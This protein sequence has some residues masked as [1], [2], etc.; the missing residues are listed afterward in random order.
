MNNAIQGSQSKEAEFRRR[1]YEAHAARFEANPEQV[2]DAKGYQRGFDASAEE[3]LA[4][5]DALARTGDVAAFHDGMKQWAVKPGTLAFNGFSGQMFVNQLVNRSE[6]HGVLA[7][8]LADALSLPR[9]DTDAAAK[10]RALVDYVETIRIGAHPAPGHSNFLLSYFWGLE[11]HARW[12]VLWSSAAAYLEFSTGEPLPPTPPERYVQYLALVRELDTDHDRFERVAS[13]WEQTKPVLLD[14]AL[15]ER[16]AFGL[17]PDAVE[18]EA[19]A[20]NAAALVSVA[21]HIGTQLSDDV[22]AAAGR[23]LAAKRP[24]RLWKDDRP[25]SDLWVDWSVRENWGGLGLRIWV[26]QNGAAIGLRAG[27][28]RDGWFDEAAAVIDGFDLPGFRVLAAPWS[29][30]GDDV[31]FVGGMR[32][33][34]VYARW[35]EADR[36]AELDVQTETTAVAASVR[37]LLDKLV[38]AAS[39]EE[40]PPPDDPLAPVVQWFRESREYPRPADEQHKADR[41]RFASLLA[42][43]SIGLADPA[44]LR[45]IWNTGQYGNPGPQSVLNTSLRDADAAEYD[46]IVETFRYVCWGEGDDADRINAVLTDDTRVVKG[47]G[48]SVILKLL[49]IC[50]PERYVPVFP[51]SGPKG[52]RRMLQLLGLPEPTAGTRGELQVQANDLI[53]QRLDRFFPGDPWGMAQFMYRYAEREDEPEAVTEEDPLDTLA[54]DLLVDRGFLDDIVSLLEDKGQVILYGPPGT[55]KT[56]LARKLAEALVLDTT[57]R[58]LVQFH[59]STSYEDFFEGY[60]PEASVEGEMTYRLTPGPLALLAARAADAPGKRHIMVIDEINRANLP[61]VLGELLY[62]FEY[63]DEQ[64]RT[65]YRPDAPFELPKDVWFI[66][67]MN[68]ADRSIALIDA[69]LRRRFHFVPIFPNQGPMAGLL[70]R[71]LAAN[72]EPSWVGELVAMVNDELAEALG[73]PHLQ[74]GPSHFMKRDLDEDTLRRIWQYNI[75][76]FMEDQFF[77]DPAQIDSFRFD[78]VLHRYHAESGLG[79]LVEVA[80][81]D[82]PV[83]GPVAAGATPESPIPPSSS[84]SAPLTPPSSDETE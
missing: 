78:T 9:D 84:P 23:S 32:G 43:D 45:R 12:P 26:N 6:D 58:S 60:R 2:E 65:L 15:S 20:A 16:C 63:R 62:L 47:L 70:D 76:P 46:R 77:G 27:W 66:G 83:D 41:E 80:G 73:G 67:T 8:I 57:R 11:D 36:L 42:S 31:G 44:E 49:A 40:P 21:R 72:G 33:E 48:E 17:D 13:W 68:T 52:K 81:T 3:A 69:A 30:Y 7:R 38:Q 53:R 54:E 51:Y 64:V 59:P 39:G 14:P 18:P 4:L 35:F 28:V 37:P 25:R 56:Y 19:L 61:K 55:G 24:S 29:K 82:A 75:E 10:T 79:E 5:R 71:W 22:S 74:L 34:F 1:W 50:H